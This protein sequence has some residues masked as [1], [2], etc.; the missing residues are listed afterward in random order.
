MDYS[1]DDISFTNFDFEPQKKKKK[2]SYAQSNDK[3][4]I[5]K[6]I[7]EEEYLKPVAFVSGGFLNSTNKKKNEENSKLN[8]SSTD[9]DSSDYEEYDVFKHFTF[10]FNINSKNE[11][12]YSIK[13][14]L[15]KYHLTELKE[16]D[17]N[18]EQYGLGFKIL[19]KMGYEDGIGNKIKTN[20]A[21][22]ELK[23]KHISVLE[24]QTKNK[25]YDDND[26]DLDN[27]SNESCDMIFNPNINITTFWKKNFNYKK[28]CNFN[29][30][31]NE[32]N[33]RLKYTGTYTSSFIFND[34]IDDDIEN[35]GNTTMTN[36][37]DINND[38]SIKCVQ[39]IQ[40]TREKLN[41]HIKDMSFNYFT[42]IKK[43]KEAETKFKNYKNSFNTNDIYKIHESLLKNIL[44]YKYLINI[45]TILSYP[46]LFNNR[47]LNE[48]IFQNINHNIYQQNYNDSSLPNDQNDSQSPALNIDHCKKLINIYSN[49]PSDKINEEY[50]DRS[51]DFIQ[52]ENK[53]HNTTTKSYESNLNELLINNYKL[54]CDKKYL[55]QKQKELTKHITINTNYQIVEDLQDIYN[56]LNVKNIQIK[57]TNDPILLSDVYTFLFFIYENSK[58]L[59]LNSHVSKFF[60]E[61]LRIYFYNIHQKCI[62]DYEQKQDVHG[63]NIATDA[64]TYNTHN[65]DLINNNLLHEQNEHNKTSLN[66]SN[67]FPKCNQ[68]DISYV[69]YIKK[70]I[71]MGI[72]EINQ[73]EYNEIE[74]EFNNIIYY[75]LIY[76]HIY[77]QDYYDTFNYINLFKDAYSNSYYKKI[78]IFFINKNILLNIVESEHFD[79]KQNALKDIEVKLSIL[80]EI[81]KQ[82]DINTYI[83]NYYMN[84]LSKYFKDSTIC[85]NYIKLIKIVLKNNLY[86]KE[87]FELVVNRIIFELNKINFTNMKFTQH[88]TQIMVLHNCI[89][90]KIIIFIFKVYF[91]YNYAKYVC[92]DIRNINH[93]FNDKIQNT[94]SNEHQTANSEK[95]NCTN[96]QQNNEILT[97]KKKEIYEKF[98]KVK[99]VFQNNIMKDESIKDI[100]FSIL[101]VIKTYIVQDKIITFSVEKVLKY[102]TTNIYSDDNINYYFLYKDIKIPIPIYA[103]PQKN[104]TL[105]EINNNKNNIQKQNSKDT[106]YQNY[107]FSKKKYVNIIKKLEDDANHYKNDQQYENINVK[108]YLQKY[109]LENDILFIQKNNRKINGNTVFSINNFSI[110]I[111]N[112]IIYIYEDKQWKPTLLSD[113]LSKVSN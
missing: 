15:K 45:H 49:I 51:Q 2:K 66:Y 70:I 107:Q 28:H 92:N 99:D 18:F 106:S 22:I 88:L 30:I 89:D 87:I 10:D 38:N 35:K 14:N 24:E 81:N 9:N 91:F 52:H 8:F 46:H 3:Y 86:K 75:N 55:N 33:A 94:Q 73:T 67:N 40:R 26:S 11:E 104:N 84:I 32:I 83:N 53:S 110:Y 64:I 16:Q 54:L 23:K 90:D 101:N 62:E 77:K 69:I 95:Q 57:K 59:Y 37:L 36:T 111:N 79:L 80:F 78:L 43:K 71:L 93:M 21:P 61:F 96:Q 105:Y 27:Y 72:D 34:N 5:F 1:S 113:L 47:T 112:N 4:N 82:F 60:L 109:C 85:D 50:D 98:K 63:K 31:K 56:L 41:D 13:N 74:N 12:T 58:F 17:K 108:D 100:M 20:I 6:N 65:T 29:K 68:N 39:N 19:R 25:Y 76:P 48:Y 44:T 102:D 103:V 42:I 7:D 97:A